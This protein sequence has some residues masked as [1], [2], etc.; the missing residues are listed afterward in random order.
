[1][2]A[3]YYAE[4]IGYF[5]RSL[6]DR[7]AAADVVQESYLRV[8]SM[9][10]AAPVRDLRALLYQIGRNIVVDGARR[11]QAE[12]HMLDT[13]AVVTAREVAG[14]DQLASAREQLGWLQRRLAVMPV[15]RREAFVLVR[16][17]G[18]SHREAATH[19]AVNEAAIEKHVVRAVC[20][21]MSALHDG[22]NGQTRR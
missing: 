5:S 10:G 20:D 11:R 12:R 9:S 6:N 13:L 15:R 17:F 4:L 2:V 21:L 19:M 14:C 16:I 3:H 18:Y 1:M 8:F 22:A 7:D